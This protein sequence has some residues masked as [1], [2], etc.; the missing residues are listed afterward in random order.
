MFSLRYMKTPGLDIPEPVFLH[1][2]F[3]ASG[4]TQ[5]PLAW[6]PIT[7]NAILS[8]GISGVY[9]L[10]NSLDLSINNGTQSIQSLLRCC[11]SLVLSESETQQILQ[12]GANLRRQ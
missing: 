9:L 2:A 6:R 1:Y 4:G 3:L 12:V 11:D 7:K 10:E 8:D 5:F